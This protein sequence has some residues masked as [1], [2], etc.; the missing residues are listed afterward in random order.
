MYKRLSLKYTKS[1]AIKKHNG[2]RLNPGYNT[3]RELSWERRRQRDAF[4]QFIPGVFRG[5][6]RRVPGGYAVFAQ[7]DFG[8]VARLRLQRDRGSGGELGVVG[9]IA[10]VL[11][12]TDLEKKAGIIRRWKLLAALQSL[13]QGLTGAKREENVGQRRETNPL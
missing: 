12:V 10:V 4:L 6:G 13:G 7:L 8:R 11:T 1:T 5:V 3:K 9:L 2:I